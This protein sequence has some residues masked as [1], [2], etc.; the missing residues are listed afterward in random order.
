MVA[1]TRL[2]TD[3]RRGVTVD[4]RVEDAEIHLDRGDGG[5]VR[6]GLRGL[7]GKSAGQIVYSAGKSRQTGV[8]FC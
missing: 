7:P 6:L 2:E 5:R 3:Q 8:D 1:D 4:P